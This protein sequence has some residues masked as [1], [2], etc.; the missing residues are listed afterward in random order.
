MSFADSVKSIARAFPFY[1][2][3]LLS[4]LG[5][6]QMVSPCPAHRPS[7]TMTPPLW[8]LALD[9]PPPHAAATLAALQVPCRPGVSPQHT[10]HGAFGHAAPAYRRS[11]SIRPAAPSLWSQLGFISPERPS[12]PPPHPSFGLPFDSVALPCVAFHVAS[13]VLSRV[14][15]IT[16]VASSH[17][18]S[19]WS[20]WLVVL[21]R[22]NHHAER[23]PQAPHCQAQC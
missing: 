12:C 11:H 4:K 10:H 21:T 19:G 6:R 14:A 22:T 2:P 9:H 20:L 23:G 13:Y 5:P 15:L 17:T 8:C 16:S 7:V 3:G 1:S 18:C